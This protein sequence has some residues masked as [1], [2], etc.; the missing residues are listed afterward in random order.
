LSLEI[1]PSAVEKPDDIERVLEAAARTPGTGLL[2]TPDPTMLRN[3]AALIASAA[4]HRLPA[5]YPEKRYTSDGGL[6]SYTIA[7]PNEP[8]RQ[9]AGLIDRILKGAKPADLPVQAPTRYSL[10]INRKTAEALGLAVPSG[11][12]VGADEVIE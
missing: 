11:L 3:R 8:F 5:V 9:A 12:L 1:V 10:V 2:V 7:D 6:M 4:R